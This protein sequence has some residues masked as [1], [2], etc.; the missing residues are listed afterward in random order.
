LIIDR[1]HSFN[2]KTHRRHRAMISNTARSAAHL[3]S[4]PIVRKLTIQSRSDADLIAAIA[5]RSKLAMQ[6]LHMRHAVRVFRFVKALAEDPS[7]AEDVVAETFLEVWRGAYRFGGHCSVSSWL[8]AISRNKM[9]SALR[10]HA[11]LDGAL[12]VDDSAV[13]PEMAAQGTDRAAVLRSCI[14]ALSRDHREVID[15]VYC[16]EQPIEAVARIVGVPPST[17]KTRMHYARKQLAQLL[18]A[19]GIDRSCCGG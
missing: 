14:G 1:E 3:E 6:V 9:I 4:R 2:D 7:L 10:R 16:H 15:L 12:A 18:S 19:A 13:T 17:V 8:F 11:A 5:A